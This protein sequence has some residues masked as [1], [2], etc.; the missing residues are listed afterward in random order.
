MTVELVAIARARRLR[1]L[2]ALDVKR[3]DRPV[4]FRLF[5]RGAS[6]GSTRLFAA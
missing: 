1:A 2:S 4:R 3:R 5:Q 6:T